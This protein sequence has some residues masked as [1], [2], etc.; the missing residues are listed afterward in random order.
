[1][2]R[3]A[4][5][6]QVT[7][8]ARRL[9][10]LALL[11]VAVPLLLLAPVP[12][13]ASGPV[14]G[15]EAQALFDDELLDQDYVMHTANDHNEEA[16]QVAEKAVATQPGNQEW[17][18]RAARAAELAGKRRQAL[19]HWLYLADQGDGAARQSALRLT[20][21]MHEFPVRRTLLEAE[22]RAGHGDGDLLKEYISVCK[23]LGATSEA[24]DLLSSRISFSERELLLQELARLAEA[25]GRPLDA[26]NAF[27]LLAQI[28]PLNSQELQKRASLQFGDG[29]LQRS[30]QQAFGGKQDDPLPADELV[31]GDTGGA[32]AL[33]RQYSW[34]AGRRTDDEGRRYLKL[35]SPSLGATVKYELNRDQRIVSN[36]KTV[37]TAHT[38]TER[39]ELNS[40][41]YLYHPALFQFGVKAVPEFTQRMQSYRGSSG[42]RSSNDGNFSPNYQLNATLLAQKPYTLTLFS[43]RIEAQTWSSFSGASS[44]VTTSYGADLALKYQLFPTTLGF[45]KSNG[46]QQGYYRS[47]SDWQEF[48]L[49]SRHNDKISGESSLSST[50]SANQQQTNGIATSIK[51]LNT[52]VSNQ[53]KLTSDERLKLSSNLQYTHQDATS[54]LTN[55]LFLNEQLNWRHLPNLQSLYLYSYRKISSTVSDSSWHSFEGRL[56]HT[57]YENLTTVAGLSASRNETDGGRQD[58]GSGLLNADYRRRLGSWGRLGVMV[59]LNEQYNRRYGDAGPVQISNEP[60]SLSIGSEVYLNQSD[61][62]L[63]SIIVT[64]SSGSVIY[65]NGVDFRVDLVGRSAML[66]RLPLGSI[67]DG[68]MVLVSYSYTRSSGYNDQLLTQQYGTTL[69]LFRAL[70]LSYRYLRADQTILSGTPP[71]RLSDSKIHLASARLDQGWGGSAFSYEDAVNTSDISYTRWEASQWFQLRYSNWLQANLRGYYGE[72][73]YRSVDDQKTTYGGT[74]GGYWSPASWLRFTLEGYLERT[75]GRLQ[76]SV[77]GGGKLDME[78]SYRLWSARIGYKYTDQND[79]I[80]DYRR[81]N[82]IL[83]FQISRTV[84]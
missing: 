19:N 42:D 72:T 73:S 65:L 52:I 14:S 44:A 67:G 4:G 24:Y 71:D 15:V 48:H 29:D 75:S 41:G 49:L 17:R 10:G 82:H 36:V 7:G 13:V 34:R 50:Y 64:N 45:S 11:I 23:E 8:D 59:G 12:T 68:Q 77:N 38:V 54:N 25:L 62:D 39:L 76:R 56:T 83:Q 70:Y 30:W 58:T 9:R 40:R 20:R 69:E 78:A 33:P 28:R 63:G 55:S 1:M 2:G 46:E 35:E 31:V 60:H 6:Q 61:V 18:R 3:A 26:V 21:S 57:L 22:L 53:V 84:W 80:S 74:A 51:T 32:S 5:Q 66:S 47:R 16:L 43:Q 37:D 27:D 79:Q 81:S